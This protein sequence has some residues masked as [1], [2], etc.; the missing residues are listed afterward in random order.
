MAMAD[1]D[2]TS[3]AFQDLLPLFDTALDAVVAM[4]PDGTIAEWNHVA[5][6]TFGWTRA[7]AVGRMMADLIVPPQHRAAHIAGV[8]RYNLTGK[9][10][11]LNQRLEITAL[12]R[13]EREFPVELSITLANSNGERLFIG[14]LRDISE[15]KSTEHLMIR[16]ARQAELLFEIS[17]FASESESVEPVLERTL[18][19]ICE[20]TGW[21]VGHALVAS[22][23]DPQE[24]ISSGVWV[25][26]RDARFEKLREATLSIRFT[27]GVGLPG[28]ILETGEPAWISDT[29]SETVFVRKG[30][31]FGAAFG[32]PLKSSGRILAVLEFFTSAKTLPDTELLLTV[33]TLGEQVGRVAERRWSEIARAKA[34][35]QASSIEEGYRRIFEQTSDLVF[36]ADLEQVITDCNPAAAAALGLARSEVLG[37]SI[38][39]FVS[40]EDLELTREMLRQKIENG[41]TT[42]Y[43]LRV[44]NA[45]GQQLFWEMN[46]GLTYDEEFRPVGLHVLAR[47]ITARKRWDHHQRLLVAELNHR[48]KNTLSI[49]QSLAHQSFTPGSLP[50]DAIAAYEGRLSALAAAHNLLTRENWEAASMEEVIRAAVSP[51][52]PANRCKADGPAVRL[53]PQ[54][55]VSVALAMHELATNAAKYGALASGKG[56]IE[57]TWTTSGDAFQL[58]WSERG[59]PAV[60]QPSAS[61]FGTRLITRVLGADLKASI[62]FDFHPDGLVCQVVGTIPE[63]QSA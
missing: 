18:Q 14:F 13:D 16:R 59:G 1:G 55:A 62:Q 11:V 8:D 4:R 29:Q 63:V 41:G 7:E 40:I 46:S 36:T 49:V 2:E 52:C 26:E 5:E 28:L 47:D 56:S 3:I 44:R 61:G 25:G 17:Q 51:F 57:V 34:E 32:F 23:D 24:L 53:P 48:V 60:E 35:A 43:E 19:A 42:R 10:T 38:G 30:L 21:P 20:L 50:E 15:R 22:P 9:A 31:G 54:A 12:G 45:Q 27:A 33:R 6:R 39:D 37:R 58:Q